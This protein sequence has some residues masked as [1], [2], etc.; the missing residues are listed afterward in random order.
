VRTAGRS[1]APR[2]TTPTP[3]NKPELFLDIKRQLS[4]FSFHPKY[5]ENGQVFVFISTAPEGTKGPPMR[6]V[7]RHDP[8]EVT[9]PSGSLNPVDGEHILLAQVA[10]SVHSESKR[11]RVSPWPV[12]R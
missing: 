7:S 9:A 1:T 2:S 12:E 3:T 6:R 8:S 10:R 5:K 4:A 11:V